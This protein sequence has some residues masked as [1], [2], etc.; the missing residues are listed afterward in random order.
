[1]IRQ[2]PEVRLAGLEDGPSPPEPPWPEPPLPPPGPPGLAATSRS[3]A[4]AGPAADPIGCQS[5]GPASRPFPARSALA[6]ASG[7]DFA[8]SATASGGTAMPVPVGIDNSVK[9]GGSRNDAACGTGLLV[10][11]GLPGGA[12]CAFALS[13]AAAALSAARAV[14]PAAASALSAAAASQPAPSGLAPVL[15][16]VAASASSLVAVLASGLLRP[17]RG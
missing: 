1:M 11:V 5:I 15:A 13:A 9:T 10:S 8:D 14:P 12:G 17:D 6:A 4:P 16:A 2:R 3:L 7:A